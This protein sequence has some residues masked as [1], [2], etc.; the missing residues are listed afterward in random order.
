MKD[1]L[2][3]KVNFSSVVRVGGIVLLAF[4]PLFYLQFAVHAIFMVPSQGMMTLIAAGALGLGTSRMFR[5]QWA[6]GIVFLGTIPLF[7]YHIPWTIID[8]GEMPFL[9]GSAMVPALA[10]LAWL[11]R[12]WVMP[13]LKHPSQ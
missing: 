1:V 12:R 4:L 8:P 3:R 10:G 6:S 2:A 13:Q 5:R 11:F 9:I 7:L